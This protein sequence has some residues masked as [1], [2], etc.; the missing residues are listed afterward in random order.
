[1]GERLSMI[2]TRAR[3]LARTSVARRDPSPAGHP[4]SSASGTVARCSAA[5]EGRDPFLGVEEEGEGIF[6]RH[7]RE[8]GEGMP[9]AGMANA[10]LVY[11]SGLRYRGEVGR[12]P[13]G[14]SAVVG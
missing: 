14:V 10:L 5:G 7:Q 9:L 4:A 11:C 12:G 8:E 13:P 1:M 6:Q 2:P 3:A